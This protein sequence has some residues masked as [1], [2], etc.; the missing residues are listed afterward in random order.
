MSPQLVILV[1]EEDDAIGVMDKME[2]HRKGLLHRAFSI[3]I[4]NHRG[5][6]LLQ[7]RSLVKYHSPGL[8]T[9]TCCSHPMPGEK[10]EEAAKRRLKEELGITTS[11]R[12]IFSFT[13]KATM[14]NGLV[15]HEFD[16]VF[17]GE[18]EGKI[19]PDVN[20]VDDYKYVSILEIKQQLIN[21]P[22][23]FTKWFKIVFPKIEMWWKQNYKTEL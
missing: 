3:F 9:N 15:E 10:L 22:E 20:E 18:F 6:L 12:D 2:V 14:E 23:K 17:T 11:L 13:Y 21:Y 4:F 8:W 7:K 16:H 1:N 5:L 19:N